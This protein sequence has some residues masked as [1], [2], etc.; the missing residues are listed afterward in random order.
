MV[1]RFLSL[2]V[3]LVALAVPGHPARAQQ[4][5]SA[6]DLMP[7]WELENGNRMAGLRIVLAPGWKTYWRAPQ[8]NGI[9]PVFDWSRSDNV[10]RA[11]VHWPRP[12]IFESFGAT[13]I[14]YSNEVILPIEI[15]PERPDAQ[16]ELNLSMF[17]GVCSDVCIPAETVEALDIQ[18]GEQQG[19][20]A[21]RAALG[22]TA[23][24]A[25]EAGITGHRC[26]IHPAGDDFALTAAMDWPGRSWTPEMVVIESGSEDVWIDPEQ[27]SGAADTLEVA[28]GL[29]YFGEGP[30]ALDRGALRMTL[31]GP[32]RA[33]ELAGCPTAP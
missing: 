24:G 7:G 4:D 29:A 2:S 32:G 18:P 25:A 20:G 14:G 27:V 30:F 3:A 33:V 1:A 5:V 8:G 26:T 11:V 16:L 12:E 17:Y 31:F 9:P 21:I 22:T 10:A 28:A 15:T 19:A 6:V 13:S 23:L